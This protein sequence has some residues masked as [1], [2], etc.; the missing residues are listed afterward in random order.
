MS[1]EQI[2]ENAKKCP[3]YGCAGTMVCTYYSFTTT[4]TYPKCNK[5]SLSSKSNVYDYY[6]KMKGG[7]N[8][9]K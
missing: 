8:E 9:S 5:N 4:C 2:I 1:N 7:N 3:Y 6:V